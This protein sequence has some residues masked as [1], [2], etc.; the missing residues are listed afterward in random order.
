MLRPVRPSEKG[1]GRRA[2]RRRQRRA[3]LGAWLRHRRE[4]RLAPANA[5]APQ[6]RRA[7]PQASRF[8]YVTWPALGPNGAPVPAPTSRVGGRDREVL[9]RACAV[10]LSAAACRRVAR[11][12]LPPR[13]VGAQDQPQRAGVERERAVRPAA[14]DRGATACRRRRGRRRGRQPDRRAVARGVG[15]QVGQQPLHLLEIGRQVATAAVCSGGARPSAATQ[16][17]G[18]PAGSS[19]SARRTRRGCAPSR[20]SRPARTGAATPAGVRRVSGL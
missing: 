15:L 10:N 9:R 4:R 6:N 20:P 13:E 19:P 11:A 16:R 8:I 17:S 5:C 18:V 2:P 7:W 14:G 3:F 1:G 12:A